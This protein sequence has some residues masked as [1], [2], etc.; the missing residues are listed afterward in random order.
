MIDILFRIFY[1]F[2]KQE[3]LMKKRIRSGWM[4]TRKDVMVSQKEL[5]DISRGGANATKKLRFIRP[6]KY[7]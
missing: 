7:I 5:E 1:N 2:L 3:D 6:A 4:V